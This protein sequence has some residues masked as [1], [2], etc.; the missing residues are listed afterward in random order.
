MCTVL[1]YQ[2]LC[3]IITGAKPSNLLIRGKKNYQVEILFI[4][5]DRDKNYL[6][7]VSLSTITHL[8]MKIVH[9]VLGSSA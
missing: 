3:T 5:D 1:Y 2:K 8:L 7:G 6:K 9:R 4:F